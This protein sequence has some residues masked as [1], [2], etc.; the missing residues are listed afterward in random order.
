MASLAVPRGL[1]SITKKTYTCPASVAEKTHLRKWVRWLS[2]LLPWTIRTKCKSFLMR[3]RFFTTSG[4]GAIVVFCCF[5]CSSAHKHETILVV[6]SSVRTLSFAIKYVFSAR[7]SQQ[8]KTRWWEE[9]NS[10]WVVLTFIFQT[11]NDPLLSV[12][13]KLNRLLTCHQ[14]VY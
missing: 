1:W 4:Q 14:I 8:N 5:P 10:E 6:H 2:W 7:K 9:E 13:I 11:W 3:N 12:L